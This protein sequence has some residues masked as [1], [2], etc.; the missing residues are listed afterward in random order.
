MTATATIA[1]ADT[2]AALQHPYP[3]GGARLVLDDP[4]H[5]NSRGYSWDD[6]SADCQFP[7]DGY[8]V[9][10]AV[11]SQLFSCVGN[12]TNFNN[13]AYEAQMTILQGD[14]GGLFLRG[15]ADSAKFYYFRFTG[16]TGASVLSDGTTSAFRKGADKSNLIGV[17]T[18]GNRFTLY[19]NH[20]QVKTV[21]NPTFSQG[22]IGL[23]ASDY[24]SP[25]EVVFT[26]AK[27]WKL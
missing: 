2:M 12:A 9:A 26:H 1:A 6:D 15:D 22:Q 11:H 13:F 23:V 5:D 27:V 19:V 24:H 20:Q 17:V 25:T 10:T 16:H 21:T 4:L 3:P 18:Q 14:C 7:G 8:H